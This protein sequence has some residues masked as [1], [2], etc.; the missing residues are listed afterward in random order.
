MIETY[1]SMVY[2]KVQDLLYQLHLKLPSCIWFSNPP[3]ILNKVVLCQN[4]KIPRDKNSDFE[5]LN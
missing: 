5:I 2:Q 1:N 4:P 3:N